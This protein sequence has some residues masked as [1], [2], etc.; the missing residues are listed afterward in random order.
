[1]NPKVLILY[2][3]PSTL[4]RL[5]LDREHK[6][7]DQALKQ[8]GHSSSEVLRRHAVTVLDVTRELSGQR[9]EVL[10]FSGHGSSDG[11]YVESAS[12]NAAELLDA[13]KLARIVRETQPNL[14]AIV[15]MSC[16][17]SD[18]LYHF[19]IC[20]PYIVSVY[21]QADD[22]AAIEFV[23]IFYEE[24]LRSRSVVGAFNLAQNFVDENLSV[25]LYRKQPLLD[26]P[27][28][29]AIYP[30]RHR[31][32][33]FVD[34]SAA[35]QSI[36]RAKFLQTLSRKIRLHRWLFEGERE[37]VVIPVGQYFAVFSWTNA[38]DLIACHKVIKP[39]S[40]LSPRFHEVLADIIVSYNDLYLLEYR[41][42]SS[43][44]DDS[45]SQVLKKG[46]DTLH[47]VFDRFFKQEENFII[48]AE[49]EPE[50]MR[51]IRAMCWAN[52]RKADEKFLDREFSSA[53]I[54]AETALSSFHDTVDELL[55]K[56]SD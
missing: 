48:L 35:E 14:A 44:V 50:F 36:P 9:F 52:L 21:G 11:L 3:S 7:I 23:G 49:V 5:R 22:D 41:R 30:S 46:I 25:S 26:A 18:L 16:Y 28:L 29:L 6:R 33:I 24:Y 1:M 4:D 54:F 32:P 39:Q 43:A 38:Y 55:A 47:R 42:L 19:T 12:G 13:A 56:V 34:L 27:H 51:Q 17:S 40:Q 15:L 2:S 37:A 8:I 45:T 31:D 10:H 53:V 20:A